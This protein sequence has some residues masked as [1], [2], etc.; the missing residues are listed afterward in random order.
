MHVDHSCSAALTANLAWHCRCR[1]TACKL[2]SRQW[3]CVNARLQLYAEQVGIGQTMSGNLSR[4]CSSSDSAV[5]ENANELPDCRLTGA[6][7]KKVQTISSLV[8][9]WTVHKLPS[10]WELPYTVCVS[11]THAKGSCFIGQAIG[12]KY[13]CCLGCAAQWRIVSQTPHFILEVNSWQYYS[14]HKA[15]SQ[16]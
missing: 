14:M 10:L 13:W 5:A 16:G 6:K 11:L 9:A 8:T 3:Q 15:S 7:R 1:L 12:C 4:W 2:Y